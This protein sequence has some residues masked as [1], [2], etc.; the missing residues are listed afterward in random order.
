MAVHVHSTR[1][2]IT[3]N[4]QQ[5]KINALVTNAVLLSLHEKLD[6]NTNFLGANMVQ[7]GV[8]KEEIKQGKDGK[9]HICIAVYIGL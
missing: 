4:Q 6:C 2:R 1:T 9:Y 5:H 8:I 3:T 7:K